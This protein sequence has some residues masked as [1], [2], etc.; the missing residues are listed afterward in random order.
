MGEISP[1]EA[2]AV[3]LFFS[4]GSQWRFHPMAGVRLGLDY[5][6]IAPTAAMLGITMTPDLFN[7]MRVMEGAA[8]AAFP[9]K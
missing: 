1:S 4:L 8:M 2:E 3:T 6:A 5:Q 9:S 7:D